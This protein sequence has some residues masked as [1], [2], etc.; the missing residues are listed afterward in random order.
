M[1]SFIIKNK[2]MQ[3][4]TAIFQWNCPVSDREGTTWRP[5]HGALRQ[6][7]QGQ[8]RLLREGIV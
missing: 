8:I 3:Y 2:K 7:G 5:K 6:T 4:N 1:L